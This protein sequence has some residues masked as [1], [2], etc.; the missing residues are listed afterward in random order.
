MNLILLILIAI[1]S[2]LY[3]G[4]IVLKY[5]VQ[6][7]I[8]A[9][10]NNLETPVKKSL[11]SFFILPV[12]IMFAIVSDNQ[13]GAIAAIILSVDFAATAQTGNSR[14]EYIIHCIGADLGM[15]IGVLMFGVMFGMWWL[16]I[17]CGATIL[18]MIA[19]KVK[20]IAWWTE[21]TVLSSVWIGLF[22]EKIINI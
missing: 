6:P 17:F 19:F 5:G 12:A 8:S 11:Y 2:I 10:I 18:I 22:I 9:S 14:L 3:I 13:W 16:V 21:I 4:Y 20:N 7:S 1:V 15:G